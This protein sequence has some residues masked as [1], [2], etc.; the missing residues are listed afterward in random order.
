MRQSRDP[1]R[2]QAVRVDD[3]GE[4]RRDPRQPG[5]SQ[6]VPRQRKAGRNIER[7]RRLPVLVMGQ[8]VEQRWGRGHAGHNSHRFGLFQKLKDVSTKPPVRRANDMQNAERL[9]HG[10]KAT[11]AE[12]RR[13]C[14]RRKPP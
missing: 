4:L 8:T 3:V 7:D 10:R 13:R 5:G 2:A 6:Q 1:R 14:R 9:G 11:R 12:W